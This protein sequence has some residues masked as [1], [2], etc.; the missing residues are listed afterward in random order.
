MAINVKVNKDEK[1]EKLDYPLLMEGR[2]L[3]VLMTSFGIGI[4]V[5]GNITYDIGYKQAD[6]NM[7]HFKTFHGTIELSNK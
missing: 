4:V 1:E 5:H 7:P 3:I 2:G 6:W